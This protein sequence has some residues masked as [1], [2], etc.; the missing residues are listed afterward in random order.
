MLCAVRRRERES[1]AFVSC[2][3]S[4]TKASKFCYLKLCVSESNSESKSVSVS[5]IDT[6]TRR[7]A[8]SSRK[9]YTYSTPPCLSPML[10]MNAFAI[11]CH[12]FGSC[13]ILVSKS[14]GQPQRDAALTS[15]HGRL[16]RSCH[17]GLECRSDS[18][19]LRR[20][21]DFLL[22]CCE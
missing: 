21:T 5:V 19:Q 14:I 13:W 11:V 2:S 9:K 7:A 22:I 8:A 6:E 4:S 3:E 15:Y 10:T 18:D 1:E 16:L 12:T 17:A 20:L